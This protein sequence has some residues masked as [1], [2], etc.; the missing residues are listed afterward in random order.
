[1]R[2]RSALKDRQRRNFLKMA[3][4]ATIAAMVTELGMPPAT[5]ACQCRSM[6]ETGMPVEACSDRFNDPR[7]SMTPT[8]NGCGAEGGFAITPNFFGVSVVGCCDYD[9]LCYSN[10]KR[11]KS[12]C[13]AVFGECLTG[14]CGAF[15]NSAAMYLF[16]LSVAR[17]AA[18][19]HQ[20]FGYA[21]WKAAQEYYCWCDCGGQCARFISGGQQGA[22]LNPLPNNPWRGW[23]VA[24]GGYYG[25]W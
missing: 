1:V 10:C 25:E 7:A 18:T 22:N 21:A 23:D 14:R 5:A 6:R 9:D 20:F 2:G 15:G 3:V 4:S 24:I 8:S 16:C 13:E 17:T 12:N 11:P 19:A